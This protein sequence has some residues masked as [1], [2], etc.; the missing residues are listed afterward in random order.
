MKTLSSRWSS[1]LSKVDITGCH[2]LEMVVLSGMRT[3]PPDLSGCPHLR[4]CWI[5]CN[6]QITEF[7]PTPFPELAS[8]FIH[9]TSI[10]SLDVSKNRN[11]G[12]LS[13]NHTGITELDLSYNPELWALDISET[14][15]R[16]IDLSHNL[17]LIEF[18]AANCPKLDTV[19]VAKS[20]VIPH[21]T[22]QRDE[23]Y[24]PSGTRIIEVE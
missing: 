6:S 13:V 24:I 18:R 2:L 20:Q 22:D 10:T 7:D 5:E 16:K 17:K 4:D 9:Y 21:V 23:K 11:L 15:I 8:L 19:F 14:P 1:N 3:C 12:S